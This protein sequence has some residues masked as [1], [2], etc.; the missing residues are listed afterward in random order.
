MPVCEFVISSGNPPPCRKNKPT[1]RYGNPLTKGF[2]RTESGREAQCGMR[3]TYPTLRHVEVGDDLKYRILVTQRN[4]IV[5]HS[6]MTR[7]IVCPMHSPTMPLMP[8][9]VVR[10]GHRPVLWF[11]VFAVHTVLRKRGSQQRCHWHG[12]FYQ[13]LVGRGGLPA[14]LGR[15]VL[16][17]LSSFHGAYLAPNRPLLLTQ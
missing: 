4:L 13:H 11:F 15:Y 10:H 14:Y 5:V 1:H 3:A 17:P 9:S 16:L 8:L 6:K 7:R 2:A 12:Q